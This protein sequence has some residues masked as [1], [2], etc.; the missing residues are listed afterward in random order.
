MSNA[1]HHHPRSLKGTWAGT[2][3]LIM[4]LLAV[5]L[6]GTG[7]AQALVSPSIGPCATG[8]GVRCE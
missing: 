6:L 2:A 1:R 4:A 8:S 7:V 3:A 5:T